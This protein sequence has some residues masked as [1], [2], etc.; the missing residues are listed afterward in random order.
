MT[1][2]HICDV[3]KHRGI[4]DQ[5]QADSIVDEAKSTGDSIVHIL[6]NFGL[7]QHE[8]E[9]Y[10][11]VAEELAAPF[12]D[13]KGFDPPKALLELIPANLVSTAPCPSTLMNSGSTSP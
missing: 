13:L 4:I 6:K 8:N 1:A 5:S 7:I 10:Q 2:E 9:L 11:V 12:Q 3:L